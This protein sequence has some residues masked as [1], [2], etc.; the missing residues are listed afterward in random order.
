MPA[1]PAVA[2]PFLTETLFPFY[3]YKPA[4]IIYKNSLENE[5]R[6]CLRNMFMTD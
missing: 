5:K 2:E 4:N 6:N 1:W 3:I